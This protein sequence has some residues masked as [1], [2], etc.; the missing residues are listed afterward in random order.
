MNNDIFNVIQKVNFKDDK[1]NVYI[2]LSYE[3]KKLFLKNPKVK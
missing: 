3:S 2:F 1:I